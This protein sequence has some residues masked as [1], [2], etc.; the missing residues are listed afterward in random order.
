MSNKSKVIMRK[1]ATG[2]CFERA[3]HLL[4]DG[5]WNGESIGIRLGEL[6]L[7]H[8]IVWH[9]A[10]GYH[11]HGWVEDEVFAYDFVDGKMVVISKQRYYEL[12]KIEDAPGRLFRYTASEAIEKAAEMD[13]Y[14]FSDLDKYVNKSKS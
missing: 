13:R 10:R 6:K 12:G 11:I 1:N 8:G 7:C 2:N 9:K 3:Y 5:S 14:Y 4:V